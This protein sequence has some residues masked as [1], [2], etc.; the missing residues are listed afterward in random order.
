MKMPLCIYLQII[1]I[2]G[3]IVKCVNTLSVC[4]KTVMSCT[5][6]LIAAFTYAFKVEAGVMESAL[7]MCAGVGFFPW[8]DEVKSKEDDK[9]EGN[10]YHELCI[11]I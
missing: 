9:E 1:W 5:S 7:A 8:K 11:V 6:T 2:Y 4:G 10:F 3:T